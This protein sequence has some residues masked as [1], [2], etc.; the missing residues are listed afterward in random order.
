MIKVIKAG[1]YSTI[2]D[3]GR[4]GFQ[5]YGVPV[6]GVM[7]F[8]SAKLVNALLDNEKNAATLEITMTG[9]TLQFNCNTIICV[10]VA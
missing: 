4:S 3:L 8:Y 6:S 5:K 1:F 2:Q 9:P 10:S 7:D